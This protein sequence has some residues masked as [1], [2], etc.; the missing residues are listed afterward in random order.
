MERGHR[1]ALSPAELRRRA[2]RIRL[3]L[4]DV[5]GVLTDTGIYYSTRG[6]ELYR[7][8][9]RDG[10]GTDILR[11]AGIETGFLTSEDSDIIRRRAEKLRLRHAY[12]GI[13]DKRSHLPVILRES[14]LSLPELAYIGDD[15]NDLEIIGEIGR[16]GLTAAP[17]D[18][19]PAIL[20]AVQFRCAERGGYGAFR[21]FAEYILA[22]RGARGKKNPGASDD[23]PGPVPKRSVRRG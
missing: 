8:S 23:A 22:L 18:A 4:T 1:V 16:A 10:M 3:I 20:A 2:Q 17:F 7:F 12:L 14:G 9:R 6:E 11:T 19:V 15:V 5:D 13:K 21:G